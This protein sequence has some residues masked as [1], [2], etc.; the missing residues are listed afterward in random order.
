[1]VVGGRID[2]DLSTDL[3]RCVYTGRIEAN[4]VIHKV[5]YLYIQNTRDINRS[6][7]SY[8]QV[9]QGENKSEIKSNREK[10]DSAGELLLYWYYKSLIHCV[11]DDN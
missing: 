10:S 11:R 7:L 1:M 9:R 3:S 6:N 2:W 4:Q 5:G 8:V